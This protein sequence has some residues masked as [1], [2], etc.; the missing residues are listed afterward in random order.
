MEQP[1]LGKLL[2]PC[3]YSTS[4]STEWC[5]SVLEKYWIYVSGTNC[6]SFFFALNDDICL[7]IKVFQEMLKMHC[8]LVAKGFIY[9]HRV[10]DD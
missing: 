6:L 4:G 5:L 10:F 3:W 9:P 7:L 1:T 2:K 8:V